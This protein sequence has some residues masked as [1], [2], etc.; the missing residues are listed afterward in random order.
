MIDP[1]WRL[2]VLIF[3]GGSIIPLIGLLAADWTVPKPSKSAQVDHAAAAN[4]VLG[5]QAEGEEQEPTASPSRGRFHGNEPT[6][7]AP[8]RFPAPGPTI[9]PKPIPATPPR[10][11]PV[12]EAE[13]AEIPPAAK[14]A[15]DA[16]SALAVAPERVAEV[17]TQVEDAPKRV[18]EAPARPEEAAPN[19][20]TETPAVQAPAPEADAAAGDAP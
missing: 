19:V 12:G 8:N 10:L 15:Q 6:A 5:G 11:I 13:H 3:A 17:P 7:N 2:S 18:E 1:R 20:G 4:L 16:R 9:M 14:P